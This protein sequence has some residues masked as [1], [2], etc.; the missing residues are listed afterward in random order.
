MTVFLN[1]YIIIYTITLCFLTYLLQT[2]S[3]TNVN[4]SIP[5]F[6]TKLN[7]FSKLKAPVLTLLLSLSGLP[8]FFLFFVK[9]N[10][11]SYVTLVA[12]P[13]VIFLMFIIFFLNMLY[14]V[15]IFFFKSESPT[16][17]L[18]INKK[19]QVNYNIL[20]YAYTYIFSILF[21]IFFIADY[22]YIL[23]LL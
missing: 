15:Q 5:L 1:I 8:P 10:Y 11:L 4:N 13:V 9:F 23:K 20:F 7:T 14:Y 3:V 2:T 12:N 6:I 22:V 19:K 18:I 17:L 16:D 21:S